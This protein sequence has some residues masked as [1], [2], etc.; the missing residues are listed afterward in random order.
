MNTEDLTRSRKQ[1]FCST[2]L[3]MMNFLTKSL[4]IEIERFVSF[5]KQSLGVSSTERFSKS[6]FV[7][8]RKKIKPSAF[9]DLSKVLTDEFY[10]DNEIS[11]KRW[12]GFRLLSVDG[13]SITLP[14]TDEL[15]NLYGET[16]NHTETSVVQARVSVLYDVYN[17]YVLDALLSNKKTG[18]RSLAI[19]HLQYCR[20]KDLIIYDR[21]YPSFDLIY[22]HIQ[23]ELD[24]VMRV[25]TSFSGLTQAF[26]NSGR[27]S[28]IAEM[29]PGKNACLKNINYNRN[30]PVKVRLIRVDLPNGEVEILITSLQNNKI[31]K[32]KI[33]KSLYF[34]RWKVETFYDELK[35]KLKVEYFSGYS[36]HSILQDFNAAILVSNIETLIVTEINEELQAE[37]SKKKYIYKVN[38]NLSYGFLKD[39]I[40]ALFFSRKSIDDIIYEIK[41]LL[42]TNLVPIRP[43]RSFTRHANKYRKREKPKV[44]KNA[45]DAF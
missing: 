8:Y 35:N 27:K 26:K 44:M 23:L 15:K 16:K 42:R 9:K 32:N 38:K 14:N 22:R 43:N 10:T 12:N 5:F 40:L 30:T 45:K 17:H 28:E 11:I 13:S 37:K 19:E 34:E 1:S 7:Q 6:A 36:N 21:G 33:F 25:K 31:Y 3:F 24:Y 18:E 20:A 39:R 29:L 2:L 4:P 41:S